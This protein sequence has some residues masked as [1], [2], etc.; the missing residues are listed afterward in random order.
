MQVARAVPNNEHL[1]C[2]HHKFEQVK[3][4]FYLGCQMNH[5]KSTPGPS[6]ET[7]NVMLIG[8]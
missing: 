3:E 6:V 4:F 2:G 5:T 7:D 1:C 8:N